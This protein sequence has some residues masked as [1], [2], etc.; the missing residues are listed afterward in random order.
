M[1]VQE[2]DAWIY[3]DDDLDLHKA[4]WTLGWVTQLSKS[5]A[6]F[7]KPLNVGRF[8]KG[9]MEEA[10][11]TDVE[12]KVVKV[13]LGPWATGRQLKEL[14]RYERWHMNQ[15]V[16]AHSM[17]LYTRVLNYSTDEANILFARVRNE[18]NDRSLHLYTVYR[19]IYGRK[20][21]A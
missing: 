8:H 5:S 9:W 19:F 4:P 3:A 14:G 2:Y 18:F 1:E 17:A 15:S 21:D 10:G 12:E 11:F 20:P 6:D 16:E 13:P 7:G